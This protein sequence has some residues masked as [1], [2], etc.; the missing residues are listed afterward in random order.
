[1]GGEPCGSHNERV[2]R[3][4]LVA[5]DFSQCS[6]MALRRARSL[7]NG[8]KAQII[9]LHVIDGD[10]VKQCIRHQLDQEGQIKKNLFMRAKNA[11]RDLLH[12]EGLMEME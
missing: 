1:M 5:I 9:A 10:F 2:V 8:E 7:L 11:L 6:R 4:V 3:T 12:E